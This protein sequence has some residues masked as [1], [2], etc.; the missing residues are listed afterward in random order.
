VLAR[1]SAALIPLDGVGVADVVDFPSA[2]DGADV[3]LVRESVGVLQLAVDNLP[4][5]ALVGDLARPRPARL[6]RIERDAPLEGEAPHRSLPCRSR[7]EAQPAQR[8]AGVPSA[9]YGTPR[10]MG[11]R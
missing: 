10:T 1:T 3:E 4:A 5:L 8:S 2:R 6:S 9:L 11:G 7:A